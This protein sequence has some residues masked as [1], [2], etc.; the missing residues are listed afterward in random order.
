M[1]MTTEEKYTAVAEDTWRLLLTCKDTNELNV[2]DHARTFC[3]QLLSEHFADYSTGDVIDYVI[4][5]LDTGRT[6]LRRI[7]NV[8]DFAR[9]LKEEDILEDMEYWSENYGDDKTDEEISKDFYLASMSEF[10]WLM[11]S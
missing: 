7:D 2:H 11:K 1:T 5:V 9:F 10:G 8:A 3:M 6:A 4:D